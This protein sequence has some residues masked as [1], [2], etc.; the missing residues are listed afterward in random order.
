MDVHFAL[1]LSLFH[2]NILIMKD[3]TIHSRLLKRHPNALI[4]A[5]EGVTVIEQLPDLA[6]PFQAMKICDRIK[7]RLLMID[8]NLMAISIK[9]WFSN[10]TPYRKVIAEIASFYV[11]NPEMVDEL[12][13]T[14]LTNEIKMFGR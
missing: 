7:D 14:E 5:D 1:I 8:N 11:D 4:I 9:S 6:S 12:L 10:N 13:G 2:V 3:T